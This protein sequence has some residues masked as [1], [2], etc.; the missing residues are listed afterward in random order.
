MSKKVE[1]RLEQLKNL[2]ENFANH[3]KE[4][5]MSSIQ[6]FFED[7]PEVVEV[8]W[9]QY[10]QYFNDGDPCTF[11]VYEP[12]LKVQ[13]SSLEPDVRAELLERVENKDGELEEDLDYRTNVNDVI[14]N[15]VRGEH[16]NKDKREATPKE[17]SLQEDFGDL[18]SIIQSSDEVMKTTFGDHVKVSATRT[19]FEVTE[20]EHD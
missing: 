11:E 6:E 14:N 3:S 18:S 8:A 19:G 13:P 20:Y 10:T 16:W 9:P 17:K 2:K 1:I 15:C 4:I 5:L 12:W 7:H